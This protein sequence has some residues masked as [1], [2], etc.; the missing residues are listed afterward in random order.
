MASIGD[1]DSDMG[2]VDFDEDDLGA[3]GRRPGCA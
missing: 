1:L 3:L 2:N